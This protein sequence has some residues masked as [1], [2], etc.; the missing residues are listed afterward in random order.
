MLTNANPHQSSECLRPSSARKA[1]IVRFFNLP[2][3]NEEE[4][5]VQEI[6][7]LRDLPTLIG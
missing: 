3:A 4:P 6:L 2:H 5:S 7:D 1:R